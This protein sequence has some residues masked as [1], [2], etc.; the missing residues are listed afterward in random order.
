MGIYLC[1]FSPYSL[2]FIDAQGIIEGVWLR[3]IETMF[4]QK[5]FGFGGL[6]LTSS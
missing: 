2:A 4:F 1:F 6:G 5:G 3:V